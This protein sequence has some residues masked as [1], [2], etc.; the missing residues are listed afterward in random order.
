MCCI[1]YTHPVRVCRRV[2]TV[3]RCAYGQLGIMRSIES[4]CCC[5]C[6]FA[7]PVCNHSFVHQRE[8]ESAL[9]L[10]GASVV[11]FVMRLHAACMRTLLCLY[12]LLVYLYIMCI[13]PPPPPQR[14]CSEFIC[15]HFC[16]P[17]RKSVRVPY[18]YLLFRS[19]RT[20]IFHK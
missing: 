18:I 15:V 16:G 11:L 20:S 7:T 6:T 1:F 5:R 17:M 19:E 13:A 10:C 2:Q 3:S 14:V 9:A 4:R 12:I 8:R